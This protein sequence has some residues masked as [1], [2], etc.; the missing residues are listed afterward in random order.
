[1]QV[2]KLALMLMHL[3]FEINPVI[4]ICGGEEQR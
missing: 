4:E 3:L 1:V 2:S